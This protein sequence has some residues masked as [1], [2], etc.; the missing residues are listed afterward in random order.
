MI[1]H[2]QVDRSEWIR[3]QLAVDAERRRFVPAFPRPAVHRARSDTSLVSVEPADDEEYDIDWTAVSPELEA[4]CR[5]RKSTRHRTVQ[6]TYVSTLAAIS[7][8]QNNLSVC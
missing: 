3:V 4:L 2:D 7:V 8:A 1:I 5:K 6:R